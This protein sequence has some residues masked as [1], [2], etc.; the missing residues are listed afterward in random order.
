MEKE[1][2][3]YVYADKGRKVHVHVENRNETYVSCGD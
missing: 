1:N 2:N 3:M